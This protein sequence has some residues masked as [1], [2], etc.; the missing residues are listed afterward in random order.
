MLP[1]VFAVF[2]AF[3]IG[4]S[5]GLILGQR[6]VPTWALVV[7]AAAMAPLY[8]CAVMGMPFAGLPG[9]LP[10]ILL[11][12]VTLAGPGAVFFRIGRGA[13]AKA[14]ASATAG[15]PRRSNIAMAVA[16][17]LALPVYPLVLGTLLSRC[18][19]AQWIRWRCDGTI[20]ER[21]RHKGN[22]NN[23]VIE[24]Q[25]GEARE[26]FEMVDEAFWG[27][28]RPGQRLAKVAGSP[29]ATL[30]GQRLRMVPLQISW[31]RDPP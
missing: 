2:F 22:H 7:V 3:A 9:E 8:F 31:W 11:A 15:L 6:T 10:I 17:G 30:D 4:G 28:A 5:A 1:S 24:A 13:K 14:A 21:S 12:S 23:P 29:W 26:S 25:C 16:M 18:N 20:V 27:S 19:Y